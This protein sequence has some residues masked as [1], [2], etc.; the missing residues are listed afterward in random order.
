MQ[1]GFAIIWQLA[2]GFYNAALPRSFCFGIRDYCQQNGCHDD[3]QKKQSLTNVF[4]V[5]S[6]SS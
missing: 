2:L 6:S 1:H 5:L 4:Y 3:K